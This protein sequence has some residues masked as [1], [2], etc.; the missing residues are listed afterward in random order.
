MCFLILESK[1]IKHGQEVKRQTET[2]KEE[3]EREEAGGRKK[4]KE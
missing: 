4:K 2:K 3:E 1:K